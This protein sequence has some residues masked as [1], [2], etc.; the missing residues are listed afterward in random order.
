MI[1]AVE[2]LFFSELTAFTILL[3]QICV[4]NLIILLT[5]KYLFPGLQSF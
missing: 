1:L 5:P 4:N 3:H 2:K